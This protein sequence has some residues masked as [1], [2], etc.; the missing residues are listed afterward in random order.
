VAETGIVTAKSG[1]ILTA[2]AMD[3]LDVIWHHIASATGVAMADKVEGDVQRGIGRL[4]EHPRLGHT[5]PD[6]APG[7]VRFWPIHRFLVVYL[8]DTDPLVVM[9]VAHGSQD[10]RAL[11]HD[12]NA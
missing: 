6:V 2:R 4:V 8:P 7:S 9:R 5:M 10:L 3:D 1:F 11:F 12:I